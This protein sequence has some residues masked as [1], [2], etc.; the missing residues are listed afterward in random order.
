MTIR[1]NTHDLI[2]FLDSLA[3]IDSVAMGKL[4]AARVPCNRELAEHPT[5][6]TGSSEVGILG[7]LNGFAGTFDDGP[8][9]GWGPIT[10]VVEDDGRVTSFRWTDNA[11]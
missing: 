8:K 4:I 2:C 3:R 10:A 1:S 9:K 11:K 5:V 7:V 6:Q